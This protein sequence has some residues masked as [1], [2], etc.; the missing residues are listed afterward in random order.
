MNLGRHSVLGVE[1][2]AVDYAETVDQIVTAAKDGRWFGVAALPVHSVMSAVID[3]S[4]A[5]DIANMSLRV[6]DGQ[7]VRW[8]LH[9]LYGIKLA[10]RVYGPELMLRLCVRATADALPVFLFGSRPE[11]LARLQERLCARF[12]GLRIAGA[13]CG[14]EGPSA[15]VPRDEDLR[16]ISASGAKVL[17]VALGC[18]K[19]EQWAAQTRGRLLMPVVAVGAAFDFHAGTVAQAPDYLQRLGLEWLF[20]LSKEPRRLW[21]RYLLLNPAYV[22]LIAAQRILQHRRTDSLS[23]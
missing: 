15:A 7:P 23:R 14:P 1:I 12:P 16:A 19:Q 2:D 5:A 11:V 21:R 22:A 9:V 17:F 20:R 3:P 18:P 10:D 4:F 6:P 13:L 8:A